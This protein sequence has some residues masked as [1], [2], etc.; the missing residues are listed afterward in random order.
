[1]AE[2]RDPLR[3]ASEGFGLG[4]EG[5]VQGLM[6]A[7][8]E[9]LRQEDIARERENIEWQRWWMETIEGQRQE[10]R[11]EDI[12]RDDAQRAED[13]ALTADANARN[14]AA[15]DL[16]AIREAAARLQGEEQSPE[17][18][19]A[20]ARSQAL[21]R[22][23]E[24]V[25]AS[26]RGQ[27]EAAYQRVM[28]GGVALPTGEETVIPAG[29]FEGGEAP[30]QVIP[31]MMP[32]V[33][34]GVGIAGVAG[35]A[36]AAGREREQSDAVRARNTE[37][38][39]SA[40]NRLMTGTINFSDPQVV[41]QLTS[42]L[43]QAEGAMNMP[44]LPGAEDLP[45]QL[46]GVLERMLSAIPEDPNTV[47]LRE[48][49][50][51]IARSDASTAESQAAIARHGVT[52]AGLANVAAAQGIRLG[53]VTYDQAVENLR[54]AKSTGF[55]DAMQ[56]WRETGMLATDDPYRQQVIDALFGQRSDPEAA[57]LAA[58]QQNYKQWNE[59]ILTQDELM[60][61]AKVEG[62]RRNELLSME[63]DQM[64]Y[65]RSRQPLTDALEDVSAVD[66]IVERAILQGD[67]A[68]LRELLYT[69][70]NDG[71]SD[72]AA[73]L[74]AGGVT[75]EG[76]KAQIRQAEGNAEFTRRSREL[77]LEEAGLAME[78]ARLEGM[79]L[80]A[81]VRS[82]MAA[83]L[84]PDE[85]DAWYLGLSDEDR[86]LVGGDIGLAGMRRDAAVMDFLAREPVR[87]HA[88]QMASALLGTVQE[89]TAEQERAAER[90]YQLILDATGDA[91]YAASMAEGA[92]NAWQRGNTAW[93]ME[94]LKHDLN[95]NLLRAQ[96]NELNA[97]A[98]QYGTED[99]GGMT[100]ESLNALRAAYAEE[101]QAWRAIQDSVLGQMQQNECSTLQWNDRLQM[102][103]VTGP[104]RNSGTPACQELNSRY[105]ETEVVLVG[106]A[107]NVAALTGTS[108]RPYGQATTPVPI[109]D[110]N[111]PAGEPTEGEEA[112]RGT[113]TN[114]MT[115]E[116]LNEPPPGLVDVGVTDITENQITQMAEILRSGEGTAGQLRVQL[117][118]TGKYTPAQ[119]DAIIAMV[120][121]RARMIGNRR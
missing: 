53:E 82:R 32:N 91:R 121:Q 9:R 19:L 24:A 79:T 119:R 2:Y 63:M 74:R 87:E 20:I 13:Q 80:S 26:P 6:T 41:A 111:A 30:E 51:R 52:A 1:M 48:I 8:Q 17:V 10:E 97:R 83:S 50:M 73:A 104:G 7:R 78:R 75:A 118:Q 56:R 99:S 55:S 93:D 117:V 28:S 68:R 92:L 58:S 59:R 103:E 22:A 42:L 106:I 49:A 65:I 54:I 67:S 71:D 47:E 70:V 29:V 38:V 107:D 18:S 40:L 72:L 11:T 88:Y 69:L 98:A 27:A 66:S 62:E 113:V 60:D 39:Q 36:E 112:P 4:L 12:L 116:A 102:M 16:Q 114:P 109:P 34:V 14:A 76:L 110:P 64:E 31:R 96:A 61:I 86:A 101:R 35:T 3:S 105:A 77:A 5:L 15:A 46:K 23:L 81:D 89:T 94:V 84:T 37:Y 33:P 95:M 45:G 85:I 44:L 57:F 43:V 115:P 25:I 108:P 21:I 90:V 100:P 120:E